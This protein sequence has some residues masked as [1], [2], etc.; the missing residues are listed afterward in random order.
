MKL[1]LDENLPHELRTFLGGH[2][3]FTASYMGWT[4][5][6]NGELLAR[7]AA[8]G[9]DAL[10]SLDAGIAFQQNLTTLPCSVV[11]VRARSNKVDD[12]QPLV[13]ALLFSRT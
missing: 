7:A 2:Q 12:L 10:I 13:P 3:V 8:E 9:F 4:G 1:L 6:R 5:L 11:I